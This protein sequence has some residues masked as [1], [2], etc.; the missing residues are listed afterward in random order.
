V[1]LAAGQTTMRSLV[2]ERNKISFAIPDIPGRLWT[3]KPNVFKPLTWIN[4][5]VSQLN[6][7]RYYFVL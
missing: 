7:Y 6:D 2:Q 3:F 4:N 5:R 1:K